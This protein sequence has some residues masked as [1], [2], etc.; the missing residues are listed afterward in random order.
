MDDQ[1]NSVTF[2]LCAESGGF[3]AQTLL[4]VDCLR[5]FGGRLANARILVV[6]PRFGPS[7]ESA[8]LAKFRALDVE[9]VYSNLSNP[10]S[11]YVYMNKALA[12]SLG[13]KLSRSE[14][15]I[16]LDSDVLVVREPT[17]LL[18]KS[19]ED[20]A[21]C[22]LDK[23]IGSSGPPD[24]NENYWGALSQA[25]GVA[26]ERLPWVQTSLDQQRVRFRLHSGVY[27]FR[28]GSGLGD[29]FV[30]D[31]ERMLS[32]GIGFSKQLP[33]PGDD[34]ALA[35]SVCRL[36]L[37]WRQLPASAN[38]EMTPGSRWYRREDAADGDVLHYHKALASSAGSYWLL[39]ELNAV[40]PDV[41]DWLL[42][43]VPLPTKVG[44]TRRAVIRR[45]LYELR[46][47]RQAQIEGGLRFPASE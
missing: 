35:F 22:S 14:Q 30:R 45:A 16:W 24:R 11:W 38:V 39:D 20:F 32:C 25:Y 31:M 9:Y 1:A 6:T 36:D 5:Q 17:S 43:R 21:C 8:T 13:D 7:L 4:A 29:A 28:S 47:R 19:N 42:R 26:L 40:R 15:L 3:E 12:A 27:S 18:L 37:A 46:R 2:L 44:G 41:A 23:N 10:F 34:V 33:F